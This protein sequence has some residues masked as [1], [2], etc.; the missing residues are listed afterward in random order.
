[1]APAS[2]SLKGG[3]LLPFVSSGQAGSFNKYL[4]IRCQLCAN[5][6][7]AKD[8]HKIMSS[9]W[10]K[11]RTNKYSEGRKSLPCWDKKKLSI[12]AFTGI[13]IFLLIGTE[14]TPS[15]RL[16]L[17]HISP[18][19]PVTPPWLFSHLSGLSLEDC[20]PSSLTTFSTWMFSSTSSTCQFFGIQ[21]NVSEL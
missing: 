12:S 17:K 8:V 3:H 14:S 18:H 19:C 2:Y 10:Q 9:G 7:S 5:I 20:Q 21:F 11:R 1:M 15:P 16:S 13:S 6:T 4:F